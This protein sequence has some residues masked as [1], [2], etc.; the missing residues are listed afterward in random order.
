MNKKRQPNR[1]YCEKRA[2]Q[3]I[4]GFHYS[5]ISNVE[6]MFFFFF[7]HVNNLNVVRGLSLFRI[8]FSALCSPIHFV[9]LSSFLVHCFTWI[10][11]FMLPFRSSVFA[12]TPNCM[13]YTHTHTHAERKSK[14]QKQSN[15]LQFNYECYKERPTQKYTR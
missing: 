10:Y 11:L 14:R 9:F 5:F 7:I 4:D 12:L 8:F 3:Q 2:T 15:L 1:K 6:R 13:K